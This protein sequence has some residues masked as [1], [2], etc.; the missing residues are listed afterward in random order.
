M[1]H[2]TGY[3]F[4]LNY[5][6]VYISTGE[7]RYIYFNQDSGKVYYRNKIGS[8]SHAKHTGI[9]IGNDLNGTQWWIHNHYHV[10]KASITT[11]ENFKQ[12]LPIYIYHEYCSNSWRTVIEKGLQ[13][14]LRGEHYKPYSYNCQTLV[15][16][17]CNNVRKSEDAERI[18]GGALLGLGLFAIVALIAGSGE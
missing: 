11:G 1:A 13:H 18:V 12:N 16:D 3:D 4:F 10:G 6:A 2:M 15:N 9:Y 7:T 5:V 17:S 8:P 14:I